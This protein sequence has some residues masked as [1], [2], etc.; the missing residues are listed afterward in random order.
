MN[1]TQRSWQPPVP[2]PMTGDHV[3]LRPLDPD[4]DAAAL[5]ALSHGTPQ[6]EAIWRFLYYGPF[7]DAESMKKWMQDELI[8]KPDLMIWTIF[9]RDTNQPVGTTG[10]MSITPQHGR[11]EI[12]HVWLSPTV[13]KTK[14]N[15]ESQYLLLRHLFDE[16][17]YRR[18]EWRCDSLN[19]ASRSA[20]ARMGFLFEGRFRQHMFLRGR[21]RDTEWFAMTDK[22]WPRCKANFETWLTSHGEVSL[23]ELNSG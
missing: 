2:G 22:E 13:Q 20:A 18:V 1:Q 6:N 11:A 12:G 21:N 16:L 10:L 19:H 4:R 8:G 17:L 3:V 9:R 5:F 15:T 7:A 14:I 23:T